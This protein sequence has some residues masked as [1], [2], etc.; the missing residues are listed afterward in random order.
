MTR[1][2]KV[3]DCVVS[4]MGEGEP[5]CCTAS[6]EASSPS[7][8]PGALAGGSSARSAP[9][10]R[11]TAQ[12]NGMADHIAIGRGFKSSSLLAICSLGCGAE[13]V[14]VDS[15]SPRSKMAL[16]ECDLVLAAADG[17]LEVVRWVTLCDAGPEGCRERRVASPVAPAVAR[18]VRGRGIGCEVVEGGRG[19]IAPV[20]V[21]AEE[22][23]RGGGGSKSSSRRG[24]AL[25]KL[26]LLAPR[27]R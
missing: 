4:D 18:R 20:T 27:R 24:W 22:T 10:R 5:R 23:G 21:T 13:T 8:R 26:E 1:L 15:A 19:G 3:A 16:R 6:C 9:N 7:A 25:L 2:A 17:R 12:R 14:S 11:G